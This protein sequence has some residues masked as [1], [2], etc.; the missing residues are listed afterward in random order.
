[1]ASAVPQ[2]G[3]KGSFPRESP[4]FIPQGLKAVLILQQLR[5]G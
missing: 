1:M 5:P 2:D 4:K 3:G